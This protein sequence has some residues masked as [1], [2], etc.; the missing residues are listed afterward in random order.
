MDWRAFN[1]TS[2]WPFSE[3]RGKGRPPLANPID[4]YA[5]WASATGFRGFTANPQ[6]RRPPGDTWVSFIAAATSAQMLDVLLTSGQQPDKWLFVPRAYADPRRR[7]QAGLPHTRHFT[8]R[9][10]VRDLWRLST[11]VQIERWELGLPARA[12]REAG[13]PEAGFEIQGLPAAEP[14]ENASNVPPAANNSPN[15]SRKAGDD[16]SPAQAELER[17]GVICVID[18]GAAI[19]NQSFTTADARGSR[20]AFIWDQHQRRRRLP[21][22][23]AGPPEHWDTSFGFGYGRVLTHPRINEIRAQ[24]RTGDDTELYRTI[25]Y[26]QERAGRDRPVKRAVH[27]THVLDVAGGRTN[28][29]HRVDSD[30]APED[31]ASTAWLHFV[32][33]PIETAIDSSGGS[34]Q[35]HVLDGVRDALLRS[36]PGVPLMLV[37]SQGTHAGPHDGSTLLECALDELLEA[38]RENFAIVIGA[39]NGRLSHDREPVGCHAVQ[40]V[41]AG[42]PAR[43]RIHLPPGDTTETFVEVWYCKPADGKP[44][45]ARLLPPPPLMPSGA[46]GPGQCSAAI[47]HGAPCC[48]MIHAERSPGG[49][50]PMILLALSPTHADGAVT[51]EAG[52]WVLELSSESSQDTDVHAWVERDDPLR[53]AS[54]DWPRFIGAGVSEEG[55]INTLATGRHSLVAGALVHNNGTEAPYSAHG[56]RRGSPAVHA[57]PTALAAADESAARPGILAAAVRSGESHRMSG[58]SVAA[59]TLARLLFNE[60]MRSPQPIGREAW[61]TDLVDKIARDYPHMVR[62]PV[63]AT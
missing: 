23:G 63:K 42:S 36:P 18:F 27:G 17:H 4:P 14:G 45:S 56:P 7:Q 60:M 61:S 49:Q 20:V 51:V 58:T 53:G 28:P 5:I 62:R 24:H 13:E 8:G 52:E 32:H 10:R 16:G 9:V 46:V 59:P 19:F 22:E 37:L 25:R 44:L 40:T 15:N 55:T 50:D 29:W 34:L 2:C 48:A 21:G 35:V 41:K 31:M 43:F 3:L 30:L 26:L 33:L 11:C 47:E 38:R 6:F 12:P 1:P 57:V 54:D 39:G